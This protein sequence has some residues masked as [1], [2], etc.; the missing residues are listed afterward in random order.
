M[1]ETYVEASVSI[2]ITS[3]TD[4]FSF[5]VGVLTPLPGI[6]IFSIYAGTTVLFIYM[7]Q[8]FIFGGFL[9]ISGYHEEDN[10]HGLLFWKHAIPKHQAGKC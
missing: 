2:T 7:W 8:L 9:A 1:A 3:L 10:R 4:A 5:F 6:Q